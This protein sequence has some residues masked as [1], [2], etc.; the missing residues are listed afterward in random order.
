[1]TS[2]N[3]SL[4]AK[5]G[6]GLWGGLLTGILLLILNVS[7]KS[8]NGWIKFREDTESDKKLQA[9]KWRNQETTNE[10]FRQSIVQVNEK[11]SKKADQPQV[12]F[13]Q[14]ELFKVK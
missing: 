5:W 12:D 2:K 7:M 9:E 11:V 10:G 14:A 13:I 4:L 6:I 1:M 8:Y 3:Q